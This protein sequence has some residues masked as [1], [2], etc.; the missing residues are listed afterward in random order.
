MIF[1]KRTLA[2]VLL[3]I[4]C[5]AFVADANNSVQLNVA[6]AVEATG[7]ESAGIDAFLVVASLDV[8]ALGILNAFWYWFC[9]NK[10]EICITVCHLLSLNCHVED[11]VYINS[12]RFN[13]FFNAIRRISF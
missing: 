9:E 7:I 6:T 13:N 5:E 4:A 10:N 3:R 2:T 11:N 1:G 8:R 12:W